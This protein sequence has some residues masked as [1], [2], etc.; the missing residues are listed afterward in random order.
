MIM[1]RLHLEA[2]KLQRHL[3]KLV[4]AEGLFVYL[5]ENEHT[6]VKT[7]VRLSTFQSFRESVLRLI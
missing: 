6:N 5:E 2:L 4:V 3:I 1:S 7:N